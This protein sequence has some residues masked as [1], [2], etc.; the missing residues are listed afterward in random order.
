MKILFL[1]KNPNVEKTTVFIE[2][3]KA[4][5]ER[6]AEAH[7]VIANQPKN[8]IPEQYYDAEPKITSNILDIEDN[9][10]TG[11]GSLKD[12]IRK[13]SWVE[14]IAWL[15]VN[16]VGQWIFYIKY[17]ADRK[18][19]DLAFEEFLTPSMREFEPQQSY[20]YIW[21]IDEYGLLWAEWI[22]RHSD[23][24]YK[25]VHHS[26]ELYWEHYS[27]PTHKHW[28]YFKLYALFEKARE[29]LQDARA[30]IVQ[31]ESRWKVLCTY[32]GLDDKR[33]KFLWPVSMKSYQGNIFGDIYEKMNI[34]RDKKI[35]FYPT[36]IAPRRGCV[37]LVKMTQQ[38]DS[39]FITV[40]HGF[41]VLQD[42]LKKIKEIVSNPDKVIISNTT[43][44]YEKL[45]N[46]HYDVWC[47]FLCYGESDNNNK[48]IVNSSNKLV[49]ALQAGKPIITIGNQTLAELCSE[50]ECGI[51]ISKWEITEFVNAVY[52]LEKKYS[53]YCENARRCYEERFSI[54]QYADEVYS[55]LVN[56]I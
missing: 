36:L 3:V 41:I 42:Y 28:Q 21:T 1:L 40:L 38:L 56:G 13:Y 22:N 25:I 33:E 55:K 49:M 30:I 52:E 16:F 20:D 53:L 7:I 27:L 23:I 10:Q 24:K 8:Y 12:F 29:I 46:M 4:L 50:Y 48:Y 44:D 11:F 2:T 43:L 35:I 18:N 9:V 37:E 19:G 32:T 47:V 15:L 5:V 54:E 26:V 34:D 17:K 51:A 39:Q 6:G 45:V 31:D 14:K